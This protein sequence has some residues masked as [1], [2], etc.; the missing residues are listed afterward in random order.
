MAKTPVYIGQALPAKIVR[1]SGTN[2]FRI[3]A[4]ELG[5]PTQW[6]RIASLNGLVDP[7]ID[8]MIELKIPQKTVVSNGGILF[9]VAGKPVVSATDSTAHEI[10]AAMTP[11][12]EILFIL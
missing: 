9:D 6:Y 4:T 1:A 7:W 5:D 10:G 11:G 3:A 2:L 8:G 12:A